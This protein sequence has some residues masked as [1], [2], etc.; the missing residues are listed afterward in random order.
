MSTGENNYSEKLQTAYDS[1]SKLEMG[2]EYKLAGFKIILNHQLGGS[3]VP[4]QAHKQSAEIQATD[5]ENTPSP[6]NKGSWQHKIASN[7]GITD[8]QVLEIYHRPSD[9]ELE[10]VIERHLIPDQLKLATQDLAKLYAAGRQA[11]GLEQTT[12]VEAIRSVCFTQYKVVDKKNFA[13]SI[14]TLGSKFRVTGSGK[15]RT[16]E[17]I[18]GAYKIAG[19]VAKKYLEDK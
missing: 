16:V 9:N 4:T 5:G 7:L 19:E 6:V 12:K 2:D 15:E 8:E 13:Q 1:V 14:N 10:L 17:L 11:I 3:T 18:N